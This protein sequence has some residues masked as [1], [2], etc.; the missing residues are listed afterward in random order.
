MRPNQASVD[1]IV[2][3]CKYCG[4]SRPDSKVV[5]IG[6]Y[7][8]ESSEIFG[9]L[10]GFVCCVDIWEDDD[11]TIERLFDYRTKHLGNLAKLKKPSVLAAKDFVG[12]P[13]DLVYIDANHDYVPVSED[14]RAWWPKIKIGGYI[15]GHDYNDLHPGVVNAVND[16]LGYPEKVFSYW[17]WAIKKKE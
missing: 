16:I 6:S 10:C 12:K 11:S 7:S 13:I 5:E 1:D 2:D 8:G 14:I 17:S 3:L 4:V 9:R 15:A